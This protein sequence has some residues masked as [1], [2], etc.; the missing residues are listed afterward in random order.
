M[1]PLD[2]EAAMLRVAVDARIDPM[3]V[4]AIRAENNHSPFH[5]DGELFNAMLKIE[6]AGMQVWKIPIKTYADALHI[7]EQ[8]SKEKNRRARL[9]EI[10]APRRFK[11]V[12]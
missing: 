1:I 3:A 8:I 7:V 12:A 2:L 4:M 5:K 11:W 9:G 6:T 10:K